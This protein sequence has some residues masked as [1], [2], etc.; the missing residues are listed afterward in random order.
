MRF[1]GVFGEQEDAAGVGDF[2]VLP[3]GIG[4]FGC[5]QG[6]PGFGEM[7]LFETEVG[8]GDVDLGVAGVVGRSESKGVFVV[9]AGL[10]KMAAAAGEVAEVEVGG[11]LGVI[12][13]SCEGLAVAEIGELVAAVGDELDAQIE[14]GG[15]EAGR[16]VTARR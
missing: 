3:G 13:G 10:R 16:R 8:E 2:G 5:L 1:G 7:L 4:G 9:F 6:L 15:G 12:G 11:D 14:P